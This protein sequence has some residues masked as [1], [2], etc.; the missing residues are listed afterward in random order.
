[1]TQWQTWSRRV[2]FAISLCS[3]FLLWRVSNIG[4]DYDFE[5]FFPQDDPETA[6]YLSFRDHFETDNDF[7]LIGVENE[8]GIYQ[9]DFL[10]EVDQLVEE[11]LQI[12]HVDAVLS[13]TRIEEPIRFGI[14]TVRKPLL[15][16][17]GT[18]QT[19]LQK[20][21][22]DSAKLHLDGT[23]IGNL[24][25]PSGQALTVQVLHKQMLSKEGCDSLAH[26][27]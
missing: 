14:T 6:Y 11:L 8:A 12:P 1:M 4:F 17:Q 7:I 16:W 15:R 13:P 9:Q 24:I 18:Q 20:L 25:A 27:V 2:L 26:S 23:Y 21:Q 22:L 10:G 5:S 19:A 3:L